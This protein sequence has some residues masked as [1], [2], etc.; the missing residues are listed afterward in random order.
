MLSSGI[1]NATFTG[2]AA[3]T[4]L[5]SMGYYA[6]RPNASDDMLSSI[7][8]RNHTAVVSTSAERTERDVRRVKSTDQAEPIGKPS[9][10]RNV[11]ALLIL[12]PFLSHM[13][14]S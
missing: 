14:K 10:M 2:V 12:A 9:K 7:H 4:L 13:D 8:T 1:R 3:V 11:A 5:C 6:S